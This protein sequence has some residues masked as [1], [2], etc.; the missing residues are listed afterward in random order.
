MATSFLRQQLILAN[1]YKFYV[2]ALSLL[3]N[4]LV[5]FFDRV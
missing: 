4:N 1:T 3:A 2:A 5:E